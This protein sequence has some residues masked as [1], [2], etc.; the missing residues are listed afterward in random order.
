VIYSIAI[1]ML[2]ALMPVA[3]CLSAGP[4]PSAPLFP[5]CEHLGWI[6]SETWFDLVADGESFFWVHGHCKGENCDKN[7]VGSIHKLTSNAAEPT[8]LTKQYAL[9]YNLVVDKTHLYWTA[10]A[11]DDDEDRFDYGWAVYSQPKAGGPAT[12]LFGRQT[13]IRA[14]IADRTMLYWIVHDGRD[15]EGRYRDST[16]LMRAA[17]TGGKPE[18]LATFGKAQALATDRRYVYVADYGGGNISRISKKG[19][20]AVVLARSNKPVQVAVDSSN[21]FFKGL[22][23]AEG[24]VTGKWTLKRVPTT[25][26]RSVVLVAGAA[27]AGEFILGEQDVYF[28]GDGTLMA[29]DKKGGS[30]RPVVSIPGDRLV[31]DGTHIYVVASD[32]SICRIRSSA[33]GARK[34]R[35]LPSNP[36]GTK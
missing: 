5:T 36:L 29:V 15:A 19:G 24:R 27:I 35:K 11:P 34:T 18:R 31:T 13:Y 33:L 23:E 6:L 10:V 2:G 14:M 26:G 9:L 21:V 30:P 12:V 7:Q 20:S 8:I 4:A 1:L 3:F 25:G 32:G 22:D 16:S 17:K 28:V